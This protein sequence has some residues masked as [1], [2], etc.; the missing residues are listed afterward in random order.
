M[1]NLDQGQKSVIILSGGMDST[2][3]MALARRNNEELYP[4]TFAYGQKHSVE[5]DC[6]AQVAGFYGVAQRHLIV[7]L[8]GIMKGSALTDMDLDIPLNRGED[9]IGADIPI[10][11]VP[12]RNTV[13]MALALAHAETV[14]ANRIY[15]GVN[16]LDYSGYPDCRPQFIQAFQTVIDVGTAAGVKGNQIKIETPLINLTK[17]EIIRL[18]KSLDTPFFLTHSCYQGTIPACGV[19]DACLLR[20][21]GFA[22][23][24]IEDPIPY[25]K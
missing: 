10:T 17:E 9:Q 23:A 18:G 16:A 7:N 12:A 20:L 15:I 3:C 25:R 2:T 6:A 14:H 24:G 19:C 13:F 11:Y 8:A 5:L 4:I 1:F 21:K 22:A